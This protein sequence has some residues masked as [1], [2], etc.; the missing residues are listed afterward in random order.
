MTFN[1]SLR[2]VAD[3]HLAL[4]CTL[5]TLWLLYWPCTCIAVPRGL[6]PVPGRVI[7]LSF[8]QQFPLLFSGGR[9]ASLQIHL[10]L[11]LIYSVQI[12]TAADS[13]LLLGF[14]PKGLCH[15][16]TLILNSPLLYL[17]TCYSHAST[18]TLCEPHLVSLPPQQTLS[19]Q[20]AGS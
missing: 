15:P 3:S 7:R 10:S 12:V 20:R 1:G 13:L 18:L 19:P 4:P 6:F 16:K 14:S 5:S 11:G 2:V 8:R 9:A 17:T